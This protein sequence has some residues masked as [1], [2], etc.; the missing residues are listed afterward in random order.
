M[1]EGIWAAI[2]GVGG[3]FLGTI[4]GWILSN[5]NWGRLN[6]K[7]IRMKERIDVY[8]SDLQ[9]N[10]VT[11]TRKKEI[12]YR[13]SIYNSS[14]R[15]RVLREAGI[16][17]CKSS[18]DI[19]SA[20]LKNL[21]EPY[22]T[23]KNENSDNII[24]YKDIEVINIPPNTWI[25]INAYICIDD[26][27]KLHKTKTYFVYKNH[28]SNKKKVFMEKCIYSDLILSIIDSNKENQDGQAEN[29]DK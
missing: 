17:F 25:D 24:T 9:E 11:E 22:L 8:C 4:L 2:I 15:I 23:E 20:N 29:D 28:K 10:R 3:T 21:D 13:I 16:Q 12:D 1:T 27:K 18:K 19:L 6:V 5:I 26:V 7:A 14:N